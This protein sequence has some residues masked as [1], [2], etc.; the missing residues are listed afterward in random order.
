V[1]CVI[2][3][4]DVLRWADVVP[5]PWKNGSGVTREL[6]SAGD[7]AGTFDW[8]V[9]VAD[10]DAA[11]DFSSFVGV[12]RVIVLA[13]G[14]A[15]TLTIDGVRRELRPFEPYA[16]DGGSPASC[17]VPLGPTRD[18]NV[19]TRR[20]RCRATVEVVGVGGPAVCQVSGAGPHLFVPLAG[21]VSIACEGSDAVVLD[22]F[23]LLRVRS[24]G[25]VALRSDG[26]VARIEISR[27]GPLG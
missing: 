20:G 10:V 9:S 4:P 7:A 22:R 24:G 1:R 16:F 11:G 6:L 15:M 21:E 13:E 8:R 5:R 27:S 25:R 17:E 19:M 18:L 26:P 23:D 14:P 3:Q 12:D 2:D